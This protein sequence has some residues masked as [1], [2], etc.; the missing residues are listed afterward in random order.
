M[1]IAVKT[2]TRDRIEE[3]DKRDKERIIDGLFY[4]PWTDS[5]AQF[6]GLFHYSKGENSNAIEGLLEDCYGRSRIEGLLSEKKTLSFDK[7]YRGRT[8]SIE[9][10]FSFDKENGLYIGTWK[11]KDVSAFEGHSVCKLDNQLVQPDVDFILEYFKSFD[12][13]SIEDKTRVIMEDMV[14]KGYLNV[15]RDPSGELMVSLSEDGKKL[16][17]EAEKT[18]TPEEKKLVDEG[19]NIINTLMQGDQPD[20]DIPF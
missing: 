14:S 12:P 16:A 19:I 6:T 1:A 5:V 10:K 2:R 7:L 20:E 17:E 15:S 9:Y 3:T 18:I 8:N 11:G 13:M 4:E